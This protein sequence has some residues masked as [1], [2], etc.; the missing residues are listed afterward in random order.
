MLTVFNCFFINLPK[1]LDNGFK[2]EIDSTVQYISKIFLQNVRKKEM[3]LCHE[4]CYES[5]LIKGLLLEH[6][7]SENNSACMWRL[8]MMNSSNNKIFTSDEQLISL[9][10]T[11]IISSISLHWWRLVWI[12]KSEWTI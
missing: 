6:K 11:G 2:L 5:R 9:A 12:S 4:L 1:T 10:Y 7:I 3:A 8:Y